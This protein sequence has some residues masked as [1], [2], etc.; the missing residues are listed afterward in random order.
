MIRL[1]TLNKNS[2]GKY[3]REPGQSAILGPSMSESLMRLLGTQN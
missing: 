2:T 1:S 3:L